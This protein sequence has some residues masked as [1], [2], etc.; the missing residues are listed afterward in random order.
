MFF[1]N[2]PEQT[3]ITKYCYSEDTKPVINTKHFTQW[4]DE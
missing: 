1:L 3:Y 2:H 4:K